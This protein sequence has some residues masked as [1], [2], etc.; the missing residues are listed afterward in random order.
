MGTP[1]VIPRSCR[2]DERRAQSNRS[3]VMPSVS[4]A[5]VPASHRGRACLLGERQRRGAYLR[6]VL[7]SL[8]LPWESLAFAREVL[9]TGTDLQP[10][11]LS[12]RSR[13]FLSFSSALEWLP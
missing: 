12:S 9:V 11:G 4:P 1:P 6:P 3:L 7:V 8:T 13:F 10:A 5:R 2:V